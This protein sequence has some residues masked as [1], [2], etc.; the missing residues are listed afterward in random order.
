MS[1]VRYKADPIKTDDRCDVSGEAPVHYIVQRFIKY[2][3]VNTLDIRINIKLNV[4][5]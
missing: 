3:S 1:R 2:I 5:K 4:A